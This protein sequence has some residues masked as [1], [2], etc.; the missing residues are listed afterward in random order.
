MFI[1]KKGAYAP[2]RTFHD[3]SY[4]HC[5]HDNSDLVYYSCE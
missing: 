3:N 1:H 2:R 5:A 4:P